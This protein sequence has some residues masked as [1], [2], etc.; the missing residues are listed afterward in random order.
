MTTTAFL[1]K[2]NVRHIVSEHVETLREYGS[3]RRNWPDFLVFYALPIIALILMLAYGIQLTDS[4]IDVLATAL[5]VLAGL[6]FNLLVL[7][8]TLTFPPHGE[9]YDGKVKRLHSELHA[10]IAYSILVSVAPPKLKTDYSLNQ[11]RATGPFACM[12]RSRPICHLPQARS[13]RILMRPTA[14]LSG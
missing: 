7:L 13:I 14:G 5:S 12:H 11:G 6:L 3:N 9:P 1:N 2:I 4:T 8:H 10:N